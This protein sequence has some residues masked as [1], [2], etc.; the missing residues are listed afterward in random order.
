[1]VELSNVHIYRQLPS[2]RVHVYRKKVNV[3]F[4]S[5]QVSNTFIHTT[6]LIPVK[7]VF[8]FYIFTF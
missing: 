1:M 6:Y 7:D 2:Y 4:H 3:F 8:A 5:L